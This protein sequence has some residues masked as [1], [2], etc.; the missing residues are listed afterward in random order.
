M[1]GVGW[2]VC[3]K[4][5]VL[6]IIAGNTG[7]AIADFDAPVKLL[8]IWGPEEGSIITL[9]N[10][11]VHCCQ[12]NLVSRVDQVVPMRGPCCCQYDKC[13][14]KA[15]SR[16]VAQEPLVLLVTALDASDQDLLIVIASFLRA[17]SD[18]I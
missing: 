15:H 16:Q 9:S 12:P 2:Q 3:F 18:V 4:R 7:Q 6:F 11:G 14:F 10:T 17:R 8:R 5:C 1:F 13:E